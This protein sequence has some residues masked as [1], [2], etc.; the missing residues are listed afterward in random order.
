MR[1]SFDML[2]CSLRWTAAK[3]EGRKVANFVNKFF[4]HQNHRHICLSSHPTWRL[5]II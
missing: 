2:I 4:K 3:L 1:D 5:R